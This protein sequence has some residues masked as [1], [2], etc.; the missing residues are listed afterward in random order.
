M[1]VTGKEVANLSQLKQ[2][3]S[4]GGASSLYC[5]DKITLSR[6]EKYTFYEW[7]PDNT[8][9]NKICYIPFD[10]TS[11][12]SNRIILF[13]SSESSSSVSN[14]LG[15]YFY[16]VYPSRIFCIINSM[17]FSFIRGSSSNPQKDGLTG[18]VNLYIELSNH[19]DILLGS[20]TVNDKGRL[21]ISLSN[22]NLIFEVDSAEKV[23]IYV[24]FDNFIIDR[25][26]R[27]SLSLSSSIELFTI[28]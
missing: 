9:L 5:G 22:T 27:T 28:V 4:V 7:A 24:Q 21:D 20:T 13:D 3:L 18:T 8:T 15:T 11:S 16:L 14:E 12:S 19:D 1:S 2:M 6:N 25:G 26:Y 17:S 10:N 23:R